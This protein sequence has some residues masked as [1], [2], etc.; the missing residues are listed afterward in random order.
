MVKLS[1]YAALISLRDKW[2]RM[3]RQR[4]SLAELA[5]C[6]PSELRRIAQDVGVSESDLRIIAA[7]H[8]G[9]SELLPLR[10]QL[11]GLD[12][13]YVRS[14]VTATYR[15]L[16]RTCAMCP[17]WRRCARDLA[18]GDVQAGMDS[19]C[20]CAPTIDALTVDE[21]GLPPVMT[22]EPWLPRRPSMTWPMFHRVER[23]A[24]RMHEMM[25]RLH[26]NPGKLARLRRGDAYAEARARC[27]SCGMSEKCLRW[28][29]DAEEAQERPVFCP[30]LMLF[31]ACKRE[32]LGSSSHAPAPPS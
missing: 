7:A 17:V 22:C 5:A 31:E 9:P 27:L 24:V 30:N 28:L 10:L 1:A 16:E 11:A 15:D 6:P 32:R 25:A 18:R 12:P 13:A 29:D 23:H 2:L 8:P 19:Y 26:V 21:A 3:V 20:L 14:A 4:S